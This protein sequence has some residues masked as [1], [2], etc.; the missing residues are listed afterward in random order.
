MRGEQRLAAFLLDLADRYRMNGCSASEFAMRMTR[1][2]IGQH[3]GLC[4]ETVCRLF[5]QL[6]HQGLVRVRGRSVQLI[7]RDGLRSLM[8]ADRDDAPC[9]TPRAAARALM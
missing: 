1:A 3:L 9:A 6:K 7:D 5:S 2:E 4:V 8:D